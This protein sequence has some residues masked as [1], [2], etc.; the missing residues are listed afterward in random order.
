MPVIRVLHITAGIGG[1]VRPGGVW[2][3]PDFFA[4]EGIQGVTDVAGHR[5]N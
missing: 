1:Y 3:Q 4:P 5:L 2:R